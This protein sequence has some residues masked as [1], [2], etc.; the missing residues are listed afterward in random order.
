[1]FKREFWATFWHDA[2]ST[3]PVTFFMFGLLGWLVFG[4]AVF[5]TFMIGLL[6]NEI[7]NYLLKQLFG[8]IFDVNCFVYRPAT[9]PS[10]MCGYWTRCS[11]AP[12]D[13]FCRVVGLPSSQT[14]AATFA[15]TFFL[16]RSIDASEGGRTSES[17]YA[18]LRGF[19]LFVLLIII[20]SSRVRVGCNYMIQV[21]FGVVF[22]AI[23][24]YG[25]YEMAKGWSPDYVGIHPEP[26]D[27]V[28]VVKS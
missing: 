2:S 20:L 10:G 25:Y 5:A 3:S 19:L 24:G 17:Y 1:M 15:I 18:A 4:D 27:K 6:I 28:I 9:A 26:K 13:N 7:I 16:L 14:Q 8:L 21:V 11:E 12:T 22:G 23:L